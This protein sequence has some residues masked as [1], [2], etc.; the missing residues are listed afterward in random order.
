MPL[1]V[2]SN[3]HVLPGLLSADTAPWTSLTPLYDV[4][5]RLSP[6]AQSVVMRGGIISPTD[7]SAAAPVLRDSVYNWTRCSARSVPVYQ[8]S[9]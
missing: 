7:P 8:L 5:Q 3:R 9:L 6:R 4:N 1:S 2:S